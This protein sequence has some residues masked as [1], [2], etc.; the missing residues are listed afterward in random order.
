MT[1]LTIPIPGGATVSALLSVPASPI[2]CYVFAHGAGAGM[3][4]PFMAATAEGLAARGIASLRY[5]FPFMEA[6]SKR[7]DRPPMAHAAVRSA[8]DEAA[9]RL[10][11]SP[12]WPVANR[13]AAA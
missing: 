4:H 12:S 3:A 6:G 9:L 2:A 13:S 10:P 7:P 5:Q 1:A 8:V 11:A